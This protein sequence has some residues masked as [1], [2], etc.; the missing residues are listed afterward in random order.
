MFDEIF[1]RITKAQ[2]FPDG[3]DWINVKEPLSLEKL[4]GQ[5]GLYEPSDIELFQNK[6]YIRDT[7][8][9]LVRVY[10]MNSNVLQ[11]LEI[12]I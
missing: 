5:I 4:K 3:Y 11:T 7:N 8:N 1:T 9:H 12:K 6:M 2:N 10:N